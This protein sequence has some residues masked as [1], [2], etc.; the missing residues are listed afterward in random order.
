MFFAVI[1]LFVV[2][3]ASFFF[4][5]FNRI[6][7]DGKPLKSGYQS[8]KS[9]DLIKSFKKQPVLLKKIKKASSHKE[10]AGV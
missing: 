8:E 4:L 7:E 2:V 3:L 1:T 6:E 5:F 9:K 10:P